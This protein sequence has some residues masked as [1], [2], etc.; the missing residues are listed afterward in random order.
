MAA[1]HGMQVLSKKLGDN[2]HDLGA[3][4]FLGF[5]G[6]AADM[7]GQREQRIFEQAL[8][9]GRLAGVNIESRTGQLA[10]IQRIAESV[11]IDEAAAGGIDDIGSGL[12]QRQVCCGDNRLS[13]RRSRDMQRD[14]ISAFEH[15]FLS[16]VFIG[17]IRDLT[18][19]IGIDDIHSPSAGAFG[20]RLRDA[21]HTDQ[22]EGFA[23]E[24][25]A[26]VFLLVPLAVTHGNIAD[27]DEAGQGKHMSQGQ[28]SD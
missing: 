19:D 2:L 10:I 7:R 21:A 17:D 26:L 20:Q 4:A 18:Q 15:I 27:A 16:G 23:V 9:L 14:E 5:L 12:H 8:I 6:G 13:I 22:A 25:N 28:L 3:D 24:L 11:L 1:Y